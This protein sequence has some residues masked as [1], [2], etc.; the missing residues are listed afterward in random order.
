[1]QPLAPAPEPAHF[2]GWCSTKTLLRGDV[3]FEQNDAASFIY[4]IGSGVIRLSAAVDG[5]EVVTRL[6]RSGDLIGDRLLRGDGYRD[7]TA[8]ALT[9]TLVY[10]VSG[11][12][13][14][15]RSKRQPE[16]WNWVTHQ[17]EQ[18]V[19]EVE[20]R[21]Q[22]ISFFRIRHRL[23]LLLADLA[24]AFPP[25]AEGDAVIP[26]TQSELAQL[27]GASRETT[28]TALNQLERQGLVHLGRGSVRVF[29]PERLRRLVHKNA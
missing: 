9:E 29:N 13:F 4:V 3:L 11:L 1:M 16:L 26:L 12:D 19:D 8:V 17:L 15:Q 5:R 7:A 24:D 25:C 21:I 10:E 28:S 27:V 6:A 22:M 2:S 18:R 20:R 14:V 23:M